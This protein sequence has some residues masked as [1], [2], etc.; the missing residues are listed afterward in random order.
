MKIYDFRLARS[1]L[2][3]KSS[4]GPYNTEEDQPSIAR[5]P[6]QYLR[7]KNAVTASSID[8]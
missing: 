3:F 1:S 6:G 4:L 2:Y 8:K 5:G 7:R